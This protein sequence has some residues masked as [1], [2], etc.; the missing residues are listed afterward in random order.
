MNRFTFLAL[1][2]LGWNVMA[3]NALTGIYKLNENCN[4]EILKLKNN[5]IEF[6]IN[7]GKDPSDSSLIFLHDTL[8]ILN[9]KAKYV[10]SEDGNR[11]IWYI[12]F[13]F[14]KKKLIIYQS[15]TV[16]KNNPKLKVCNG[17]YNLINTNE[18]EFKDETGKS[19]KFKTNQK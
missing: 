8:R 2:S 10:I 13:T 3:D 14:L 11:S 7:T 9:N 12:K 15:D 16:D 5:L 19:T 4:V 17:T 18:P 1:V 6:K